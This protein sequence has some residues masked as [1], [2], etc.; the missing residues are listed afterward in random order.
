MTTKPIKNVS[1]SV[2][3]KLLELSRKSGEQFN[4]ILTRYG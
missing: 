1:A 2:R 4:F 3:A